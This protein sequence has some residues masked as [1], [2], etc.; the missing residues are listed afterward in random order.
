MSTDNVIDPACVADT[1]A[2][3]ISSVEILGSSVRLVF[4]VPVA[5]TCGETK[6]EERIIVAKVVIPQ[7]ARQRIARLI[8]SPTEA[9]H[10]L[11]LGAA[12]I[13]DHIAH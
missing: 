10:D 4:V 1:F 6:H 7:E 3:D 13:G 2:L 12:T 8:G 5:L 9:A 11:A